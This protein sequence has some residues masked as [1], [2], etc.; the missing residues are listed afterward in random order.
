VTITVRDRQQEADDL[1]LTNATA[2][3]VG[4][5]ID[6]PAQHPLDQTIELA[7]GLLVLDRVVPTGRLTYP[8]IAPT[9]S[10]LDP[11]PLRALASDVRPA[12]STSPTTRTLSGLQS[13]EF[14]VTDESDDVA[15]PEVPWTTAPGCV[16]AISLPDGRWSGDETVRECQL[17]WD[18]P[19]VT[20]NY[21]VRARV[22]DWVGNFY[23]TQRRLIRIIDPSDRCQG[24][25]G[26]MYPHLEYD[27]SNKANLWTHSLAFGDATGFID[28]PGD[29]PPFDSPYDDETPTFDMINAGSDGS[30]QK[31]NKEDWGGDTDFVYLP[32]PDGTGKLSVDTP[33]NRDIE[34]PDEFQTTYRQ[35][36]GNEL[37]TVTQQRV[38][39][40]DDSGTHNGTIRFHFEIVG[41][42]DNQASG[43]GRLAYWIWGETG[44]P[45]RLEEA[46]YYA[47]A[48]NVPLRC[49]TQADC[50]G[51]NIP[52][53]PPN[54]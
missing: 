54:P 17:D 39:Y 4:N 27:G 13:V 9:V 30:Y 21:W 45:T 6:P 38:T 35:G 5:A 29:V 47:K 42:E 19:N 22:T 26:A 18:R 43:T 25:K 49:R 34:M 10:S 2:A 41:A 37:H 7:D 20:A 1:Y 11:I 50:Q 40:T 33:S 24:H 52:I 8:D 53:L 46:I 15:N 48:E 28:R 31:C 3:T 32:D 16:S 23:I 14:L 12:A 44:D 51:P 36:P